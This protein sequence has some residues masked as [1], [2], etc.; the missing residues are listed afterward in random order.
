[1]AQEPA[2][3][4][5]KPELPGYWR[6]AWMFFM[7]PVTLHRWLKDC[8]IERPD[9]SGWEFWKQRVGVEE[10][11]RVY[12]WRLL[13]LFSV[14]MPLVVLAI[15]L[16]GV[17]LWLD[18]PWH[19]LMQ[20]AAN[21]VVFGAA[22]FMAIGV[23]FG[24]ATGVTTGAVLGIADSVENSLVIGLVIGLAIGVA[25]RVAFGVA[26]GMAGRAEA[27]PWGQMSIMLIVLSMFGISG[28]SADTSLFLAAGLS[29]LLIQFSLPFYPLEAVV[30]SLLYLAGGN[31]PERTLRFSPILFHDLSYLPH[32]FLAQH[33]VK[34][35]AKA[36]EL[37]KQ[38]ITAASIA[39]GQQDAARK[40][41]AEL[42]AM[43]LAEQARTGKFSDA[44]ELHGRWLLGQETAN[45][46]QR[47][48]AETA[49]F[50][51]AAEGASSA[52]IRLQHLEAALNQLQNLDKRLTAEGTKLDMFLR[53]TL[54]VWRQELETRLQ[55]A[56]SEAAQMIPNPYTAG[57]PLSPEMKWDPSV[58]RGREDTVRQVEALLANSHSAASIALIGPRRC[59]KTSLLNMLPTMLPDTLVVVFDLQDNPVST[60]QAFYQALARR[61][62]Q[63]ALRER[64]LELPKLQEGPP[65]EALG[66]WLEALENFAAAKRILI[67]IDEFER[68]EHLFPGEPRE[69]LQFMGLMRATIQH[70]RRVRLLVS[71][72]APSDEM[73]RLWNDHFINLRE[74]RIGF[75]DEPTS[76]A[77]LT[78]PVEEFPSGVITPELALEVFRRSGGQPYLTQLFGWLLVDRLNVAERRAATL[79]DLA[80][81]EE[82]VLGEANGYFSNIWDDATPA[83]RDVLVALAENRPCEIDESCRR[84]LARRLLIGKDGNL[85][86][87]VFGHWLREKRL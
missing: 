32:P 83:E 24:V 67:C 37:A 7:Q 74:I 50:V 49:R 23:K 53:D 41:L 48:F 43:E 62:W 78:K 29:M 63:Q 64:R 35:A 17:I 61:A 86:V 52:H 11:Y 38:V 33:I 30:Q 16:T 65:I 55:A 26:F 47:G 54:T 72:A 87:P 22:G 57:N 70:R 36:P 3:T 66:Q 81:V 75:L 6:F 76:V 34:A 42:Q 39:P 27:G 19:K 71:G 80:P 44:A 25:A 40:A 51:L 1:M 73:G 46:L 9:I 45:P 77:L 21:G 14:P 56:Q 85:A 8:G 10:G 60:P 59:G 4:P 69:L 82:K 20:I 31:R 12:L 58:F 5:V 2:V 28:S 15:D 13:F 84:R 68:L 18:A 79:E